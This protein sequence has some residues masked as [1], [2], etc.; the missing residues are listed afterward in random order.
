VNH[1]IVF[2][3]IQG[4]HFAVDQVLTRLLPAS[5][6]PVAGSAA[7]EE[8]SRKLTSWEAQVELLV[9]D[10]S[11]ERHAKLAGNLYHDAELMQTANR[12]LQSLSVRPSGPTIRSPRPAGGADL[13]VSLAILGRIVHIVA[14]RFVKQT[15]VG[16][17][18][19]R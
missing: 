16:Q 4:L 7:Y 17:V 14:L 18:P 10:L 11:S 13:P 12:E 6:L 8:L 1:N 19:K 2:S 5:S 9:R 15:D 3:Q